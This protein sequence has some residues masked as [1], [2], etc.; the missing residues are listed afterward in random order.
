LRGNLSGLSKSVLLATALS[1]QA[2]AHSQTANGG[3]NSFDFLNISP[4]SR[5]VGAGEAYT[6]MGDDVGSIYYNPAGLASVLTNE[7]NA[8]Y[9]SLY[10]SIN[11]E[12]LA[13][14]YPL[15]PSFPGIDGTIGISANFLQPG[16][17]SRTNDLGVTINGNATFSSGDQAFT[18][19]YAKAFGPRVLVGISGKYIQQTIDVVQNT[20]FAMD[21]G[22]VV[23]PPFDGMRVGVA[24]KNL[25][26]QTDNFDLPFN[27]NTG[28]SYRHYEIFSPQDD[29]AL[30]VDAIFPLEP[31]EDKFGM[32][33][34]GE[35]D[36]K[37]IGNR[38]SIRAGYTMF[39]SDL[40]GVGLTI[41]AG[42]GL[43]LS[44]AVLFLDYAFAPEDIYG[45]SNRISLTTKF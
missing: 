6:A 18:L 5:A 14:A 29:G 3:R 7:F 37:W 1:L 15:A 36:F 26:A 23:L 11:Y 22:I 8:T 17:L 4:I 10:Q 38:I 40:S 35:Y 16:S 9:L 32:R 13:F 24:L 21:A 27:L 28:I 42:Y 20:L 43:D 33:A 41:G 45:V 2:P 39:D 44:G 12:F 25:G 34:G 30:S 31:I 19:A